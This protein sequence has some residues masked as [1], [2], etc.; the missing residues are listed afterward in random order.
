MWQ[1]I[2]YSVYST[3]SG[4]ICRHP[5]LPSFLSQPSGPLRRTPTQP[6]VWLRGLAWLFACVVTTLYL[7]QGRGRKPQKPQRLPSSFLRHYDSQEERTQSSS[8]SWASLVLLSCS[9][10]RFSLY[11]W[12]IYQNK[13]IITVWVLNVWGN[14]ILVQIL[15]SICNVNQYDQLSQQER[16]KSQ[17]QK[18][19]REEEEESSCFPFTLQTL[20]PTAA[21]AACLD[22]LSF[23][24]HKLAVNLQWV[25]I[26]H[27]CLCSP[28][29]Q[30]KWS[31][32]LAG[33]RSRKQ[34]NN[35]SVWLCL[36]LAP[37][38]LQNPTTERQHTQ[39]YTDQLKHGA[40]INYTTV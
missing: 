3:Y 15:P 10:G 9:E 17:Q 5:L 24:Q 36:H 23:Q 38:S 20:R 4:L 26:I 2:P 22:H 28:A 40:V 8:H 32:T 34:Q 19:T 11:R 16:L 18:K 25:L 31:L 13:Q 6:F 33:C 14:N 27:L 29:S 12:A 37:C 30:S 35:T 39:I 7:K 21:A 1:I